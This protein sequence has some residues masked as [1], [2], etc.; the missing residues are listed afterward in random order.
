MFGLSGKGKIFP[1]G[2]ISTVCACLHLRLFVYFLSFSLHF[3]LT[4]ISQIKLFVCFPLCVFITLCL[5]I[6]IFFSLCLCG[7]VDGCVGVLSFYLPCFLVVIV[8]FFL[9]LLLLW[10]LCLLF[11]LVYDCLCV[12]VCLLFV[13]SLHI[14]VWHL[15]KYIWR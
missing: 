5:C 10:M 15:K 11:L 14:F 7:W 4:V 12:N 2:G 6:F 1:V 8:C 9:F 13:L 3:L